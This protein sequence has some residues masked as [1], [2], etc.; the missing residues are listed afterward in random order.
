MAKKRDRVVPEDAI[1]KADG[2]AAHVA[3]AA[4]QAAETAL[5]L[6]EAGVAVSRASRSRWFADRR[7]PLVQR[8]LR[9]LT[10]TRFVRD[11]DWSE[12]SVH[13]ALNI[14]MLPHIGIIEQTYRHIGR[15]GEDDHIPA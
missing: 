12:L 5:K 15:T 8:W 1:R 14:Y 9:D 11:A 2:G 7:D 6:R 4:V 3:P 10:K 13:L